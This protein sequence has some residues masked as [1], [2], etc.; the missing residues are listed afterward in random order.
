M[1]TYCRYCLKNVVDL[2]ITL[3]KYNTSASGDTHTHTHT[4]LYIYIYIY[5]YII[6]IYMLIYI[7]RYICRDFKDFFVI[8]KVAGSY[9]IVENL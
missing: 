9:I 3:A 8:T 5:I 6:Y 4:P 7:N 1:P 2:L